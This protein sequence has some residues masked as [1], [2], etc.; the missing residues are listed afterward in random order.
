[1]T[2]AGDVG[3]Q[4][5]GGRPSGA[6][7]IDPSPVDVD[8]S[9][10]AMVGR[11]LVLAERVA[12]ETV[13]AA[14]EEAESLRAAAR[15]EAQTTLAEVRAAIEEALEAADANLLATLDESHARVLALVAE[16]TAASLPTGTPAR[17]PA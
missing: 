9:V 10:A 17:P 15:E 16:R 2:S 5:T 3:P 6:Q 13:A 1:M 7:T 14:E 12:R 4:N 11:A 8:Q